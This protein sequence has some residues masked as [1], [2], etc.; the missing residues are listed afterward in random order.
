MSNIGK[1]I[2][3]LFAELDSGKPMHEIMRGHERDAGYAVVIPGERPW[4]AADDWHPTVV[5]S[6]DEKIV[7]LV[8]ILALHPGRGALRRTLAGIQAAGLVPVICEPT[9]EMRA[10]CIR[11]GWKR[12]VKDIGMYRCEQWSPRRTERERNRVLETPLETRPPEKVLSDGAGEG[13]RTLDT[14][15]GKMKAVP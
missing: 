4:L 5:V 3:A 1:I 13:N 11:W 9:H 6:T 8:A 2:D 7:R 10:T 14:Q 12:R 15:L